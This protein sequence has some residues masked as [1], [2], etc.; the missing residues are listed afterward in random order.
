[1]CN[2]KDVVIGSYD[3]QILLGYY[4][5]MRE[6]GKNRV[7]AGLSGFGIPVDRCIAEQVIELWEA[8]IK[9]LGCCCGHNKETGFINVAAEDFDKALSLGFEKYT[10]PGNTQRNDTV[11]TKEMLYADNT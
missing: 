11:K 2:C 3:N 9:T 5:I 4:P 1:M 8:G 6:Y 7:K 10:Y